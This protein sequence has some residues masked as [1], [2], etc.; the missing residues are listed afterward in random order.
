MEREFLYNSIEYM[1]NG[2]VTG[3]EDG[4]FIILKGKTQ[5][6]YNKSELSHRSKLYKKETF[7]NYCEDVS[8]IRKKKQYS[9]FSLQF[10]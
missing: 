6:Q 9:V 4:V 1:K 8:D 3:G 5:S 10:E 7:N 2:R